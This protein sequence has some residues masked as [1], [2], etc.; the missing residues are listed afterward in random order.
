MSVKNRAFAIAVGT[1]ALVAASAP[2]ASAASFAGP[3]QGD[4]GSHSHSY[5]AGNTGFNNDS[6]LNVTGNQLNSNACTFGAQAATGAVIQ[7]VI[8]ALSG[9]TST[10]GLTTGNLSPSNTGTCNQ[11]PAPAPTTVPTTAGTVTGNDSGGFNNDSIANLSNNQLQSQI[12][13]V[14]AQTGTAPVLQLVL[15]LAAPLDIPIA[16][17][18]T[19]DPTNLATCTQGSVTTPANS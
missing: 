13:T 19:I 17:T 6:I 16:T 3:H 5:S 12:C 9:V 10:V 1:A 4:G 8:S 11:D 7:P 15:G 18:G 2:M 14:A